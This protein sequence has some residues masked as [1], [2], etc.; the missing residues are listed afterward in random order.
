[1]SEVQV[2]SRRVGCSQ[3]KSAIFGEG[4]RP[5]EAVEA[6]VPAILTL[7]DRGR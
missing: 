4:Y 6:V 2:Q 1:M 7:W 5:T 3:R